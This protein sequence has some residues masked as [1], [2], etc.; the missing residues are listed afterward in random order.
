MI[1]VSEQELMLYTNEAIQAAAQAP[2]GGNVRLDTTQLNQE[3]N[4]AANI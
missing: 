1:G 2:Q 3:Q 4:L